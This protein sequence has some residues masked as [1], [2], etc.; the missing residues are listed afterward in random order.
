VAVWREA[1]LHPAE[2]VAASEHEHALDDEASE[3][4]EGSEEGA[5][6][7]RRRRRRRNGAEI[8]PESA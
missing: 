5:P 1:K 7:K 3:A 6:R 2:S 4:G 8:T